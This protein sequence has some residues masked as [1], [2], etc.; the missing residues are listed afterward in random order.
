V[1]L[2]LFC[3]VMGAA[4]FSWVFWVGYICF[5]GDGVAD[6]CGKGVL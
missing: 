2:W 6:S 1:A 5:W 3:G 4:L